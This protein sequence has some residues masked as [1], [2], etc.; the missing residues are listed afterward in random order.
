M[1]GQY[2]ST[3]NHSLQVLLFNNLSCKKPLLY[4][5][6]HTIYTTINMITTR[7]KPTTDF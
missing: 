3:L 6:R 5:I 7:P 4:L 2:E 1:I